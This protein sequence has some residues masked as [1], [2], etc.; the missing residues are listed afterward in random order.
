LLFG[1]NTGLSIIDIMGMTGGSGGLL[2]GA[3]KDEARARLKAGLLL[4]L[5]G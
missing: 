1:S 5:L 4:L 2:I 3:E